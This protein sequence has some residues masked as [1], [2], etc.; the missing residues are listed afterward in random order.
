LPAVL[1]ASVV[2][3]RRRSLHEQ[4]PNA[5][6][7]ENEHDGNESERPEHEAAPAR[8]QDRDDEE[9]APDRGFEHDGTLRMEGDA[10]SPLT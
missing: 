6:E 5:E 2:A 8:H 3:G 10:V 1:D 4:Q 7:K 9:G